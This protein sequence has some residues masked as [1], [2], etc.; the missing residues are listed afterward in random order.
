MTMSIC[1]VT[2]SSICQDA[3]RRIGTPFLRTATL[4][5]YDFEEHYTGYER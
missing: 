4:T 3:L 2:I 1:N 5:G